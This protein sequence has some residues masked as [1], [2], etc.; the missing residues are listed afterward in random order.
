MVKAARILK[1]CGGNLERIRGQ[2]IKIK[3]YRARELPETV[4]IMKWKKKN[5]EIF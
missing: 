1:G 4:G 3:F 2:I 5:C